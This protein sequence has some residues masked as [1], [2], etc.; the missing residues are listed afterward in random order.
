MKDDKKI[1]D[2]FD[3]FVT[4]A[5][6]GGL[7]VNGDCHRKMAEIRDYLLIQQID[8]D[9]PKVIRI[10]YKMGRQLQGYMSIAGGVYL[11]CKGIPIST[12]LALLM[13]G[14]S[15]LYIWAKGKGLSNTN[16]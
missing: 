5:I 10:L 16:T 3:D 15:A 12:E 4:T 11:A 9:Y 13:S 7:V 6:D 2:K 8:G 14:P 1:L